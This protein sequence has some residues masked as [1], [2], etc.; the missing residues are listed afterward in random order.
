MRYFEVL[1]KLFKKFHNPSNPTITYA[2]KDQVIQV[3]LLFQR[4][5][6]DLPLYI[7]LISGVIHDPYLRHLHVV[8][9]SFTGIEIDMIIANVFTENFFSISSNLVAKESRPDY[10]LEE[11]WIKYGTRWNGFNPLHAG[12]DRILAIQIHLYKLL[13]KAERL[14]VTYTEKS[15][16]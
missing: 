16:A 6:D 4:S 3:A 15:A 13:K 9:S 7:V 14:K 2:Y 11:I 1:E 8:S 10:D 12:A 5:P